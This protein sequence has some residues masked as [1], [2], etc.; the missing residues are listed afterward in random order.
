MATGSVHVGRS[1]AREEKNGLTY[2]PPD[3]PPPDEPPP[4]D[5]TRR[6]SARRLLHRDRRRRLHPYVSIDLRTAART[7]GL[8]AVN[9]AEADTARP[10]RGD[11]DGA[12]D[13]VG[14]QGRQEQRDLKSHFVVDEILGGKGGRDEQMA[15]VESRLMTEA[16]SEQSPSNVEEGSNPL[17]TVHTLQ[18]LARSL[19][20]SHFGWKNK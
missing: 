10:R 13:C 17:G 1:L 16:K 20:Q 12:G 5:L 18:L 3:E 7:A 14:R 4:D 19:F 11:G 15:E 8:S 9:A 2:P 6:S